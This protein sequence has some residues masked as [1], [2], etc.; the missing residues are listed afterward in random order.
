[1]AESASVSSEL[2]TIARERPDLV[3]LG[4]KRLSWLERR[5]IAFVRRTFEPGFV[6]RTVR[7]LQRIIG[8]TWIH[9]FT[10][11]LRH[12]YGIE[13]LPRLDKKQ[14]FIIVSN[15]RSFFDLYV[16]TGHLVR[17]GLKHRIVFPV[18]A[19]FFYDSPLGLF[20][21]GVMSFFAMYPPIFRDRKKL[22]LNPASLEELGW[23]LRRGGML[24]G[25]H[26]EGTR[27]LS[28]DPYSFL[29]AQRGVGKIIHSA[30][31][32]VIPVFVNGLINDL[33]RQVASNF[34]GTG[35]KIVVVFGP[36]VDLGELLAAPSTPKTHQA[37]ADRTLEAVSA[38]GHEEREHRVA[39]G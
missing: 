10:K 2:A 5:L 23:L 27:N 18:R 9:H 4:E 3:A 26:P 21:N 14:S 12:V 25:L 29:P 31:V 1:M 6:D 35:R 7:K 28:E 17:L 34:D 20:V 16:I 33:P 36:P 24:C 22:S 32:P 38:L 13:R 15:H 39:L 8:S 37:I 19:R 30:G 11:H